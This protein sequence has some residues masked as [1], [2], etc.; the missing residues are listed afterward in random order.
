MD[1]EHRTR[2]VGL[3]LDGEGTSLFTDDLFSY[4]QSHFNPN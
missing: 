1:F 4:Q 3:L 2:F